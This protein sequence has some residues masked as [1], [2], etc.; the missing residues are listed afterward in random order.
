MSRRER[1]GRIE[2]GQR[3]GMMAERGLGDATVKQGFAVAGGV[4]KDCLEA[5]ERFARP[6]ERQQRGAT[7]FQ[8]VQVSRIDRQRSVETIERIRVAL[9]CV[10]DIGEIEQRLGGARIDL[11]RRRNQPQR[12]AHL[13]ALRLDGA[14]EMQR[15]EI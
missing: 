1:R 7:I 15:V 2:V 3:L 5:R 10:H 14:L 8:G 6:V 11:E 4:G 12:L 13:S 9:E